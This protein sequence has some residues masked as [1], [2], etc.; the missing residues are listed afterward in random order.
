M[1]TI[2]PARILQDHAKPQFREPC[3]YCGL[4]CRVQACHVSEN[5]LHSEQAPCIALEVHDGKYLCGMMIRP[6]NYL[7]LTHLGTAADEHLIPL[8]KRLL[9]SGAGCG[10]PDEI[11][12]IKRDHETQ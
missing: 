7:G 10:M 9:E 2:F 8:F 1:S 4:C 5:F 3:N 11:V 6:S 12:V